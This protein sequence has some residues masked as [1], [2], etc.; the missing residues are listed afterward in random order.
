VFPPVGAARIIL[1]MISPS[2][3]RVIE[4]VRRYSGVALRLF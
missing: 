3:T 4:R 2:I 1:K